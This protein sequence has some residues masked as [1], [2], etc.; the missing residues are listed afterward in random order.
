MAVQ[1]NISG[2]QFP[3]SDDMCSAARVDV[4][5]ISNH[6]I[7]FEEIIFLQSNILGSILAFVSFQNYVVEWSSK[8]NTTD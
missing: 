3:G 1:N 4:E 5:L 8:L 6:F 7:I 2:A